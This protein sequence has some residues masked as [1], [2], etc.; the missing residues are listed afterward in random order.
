MDV[1]VARQLTR[2]AWLNA[3]TA[4]GLALMMVSFA[5][6]QRI[7]AD[8]HATVAYWSAARDLPRG[9]E[10]R[11]DDLAISQVQLPLDVASRYLEADEVLDGAV[12]ERAVSAGELLP[13]AWVSRSAPAAGR[14]MTIPVPSEHAVGGSLSVGDT[15]DV[16]ATFAPEGAEARTTLVARGIEVIGVV[17]TGGLVLDEQT[18]VGITV[19]VSPDEATRLAFAIRT[20]GLDVVRVVGTDDRSPARPIEEADL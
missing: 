17:D 10:V 6:G 7:L 18:R 1:P 14:E 11:A 16:Y 12:L 20:A 4:L 3:R 2:P 15:V 9:A 13:T 8:A 5:G 19:A